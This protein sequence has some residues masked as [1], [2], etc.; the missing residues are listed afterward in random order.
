M[1]TQTITS[2]FTGLNGQNVG[3][4]VDVL[5]GGSALAQI[6]AATGGQTLQADFRNH[7]IPVVTRTTLPAKFAEG[8]T[9]TSADST[10]TTV[11]LNVNVYEDW[12]PISVEFEK[13][14]DPASLV[15]TVVDASAALFPLVFDIEFLGE[16]AGAAATD[17][18]FV[19]AT[20]LASISAALATYDATTYGPAGVIFTRQGA[21]KLKYAIGEGSSA[22]LTLGGASAGNLFDL[23]SAVTNATGTQLGTASLMA[24][25]GPFNAGVIAANGSMTSERR[26]DATVDSQGPGTGMVQYLNRAAMGYANGIDSTST[27]TGFVTLIDAV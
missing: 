21:R 8:A 6:N 9:R 12:N 27:G 16:L 4:F 11:A 3:T 5:R 18:E 7:K 2:G 13:T 26:P 1:A 22:A 15:S 23:P 24:I 25:I 17:V 20:P 19:A 14:T 10:T